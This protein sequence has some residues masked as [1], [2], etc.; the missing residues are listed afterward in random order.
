MATVTLRAF[1]CSFSII[2]LL[3]LCVRCESCVCE[4][5]NIQ[6][7]GMCFPPNSLPTSLASNVIFG[8][9]PLSVT[10][11]WFSSFMYSSAAACLLFFKRTACQSLGN[12]C[13]MNMHSFSTINNDAC[14]LY[15]TVYR[16]AQGSSQDI[17]YCLFCHIDQLTVLYTCLQKDSRALDF[18]P[19]IYC[20]QKH[21]CSHFQK[22][23]SHFQ[24]T[25]IELRAAVYS[26]RGEILRWE[27]VGGGNLQCVLSV[28][29]LLKGYPEP[30][31]YDVFLVI[32]KPPEDKHLLAVP[33]LNINQ[34]FNG[35]FTNQGSNLNNW[36]LTQRLMLV[37]TLSGR[38]KSLSS[39]P[40]VIRVAS[41]INIGFQLV[42]NTQKGQVYPPLMTV[43]YSDI[44]VTDPTTQTVIVSFSFENMMEHE[45]ARVKTDV[46]INNASEFFVL[47]LSA[48]SYVDSYPDCSI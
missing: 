13:V 9:L 17:S 21:T 22:P 39:S 38:E 1:V 10:S 16:A 40:K 3:K 25:N 31:F 41:N 2:F 14:G 6:A 19:R 18:K 5:S 20:K 11:A 27:S 4:T 29:E 35:Q 30:V 42:T 34:L 36:Y 32:Q 47:C 23:S 44:L 28:S 12:M 33:L 24:N 48:Y 8:Q 7:G 46:S 15:N 45:E 26:V 37:D 43:T